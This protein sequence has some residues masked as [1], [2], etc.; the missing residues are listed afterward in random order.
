MEAEIVVT[1]QVSIA[2]SF[3]NLRATNKI[4]CSVT[5]RKTK[6]YISAYNNKTKVGV[7][8]FQRNGMRLPR[9]LHVDARDSGCFYRSIGD[10]CV[11][12]KHIFG[13][14]LDR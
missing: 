10:F 6:L 5:N 1:M 4:G 3:L 12:C 14:H 2:W 8:T 11:N 7:C 9:L 13:I